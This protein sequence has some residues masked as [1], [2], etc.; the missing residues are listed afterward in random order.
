MPPTLKLKEGT[1]GTYTSFGGDWE[2]LNGHAA[3]LALPVDR[4][5]PPTTDQ[6][7]GLAREA[8][9]RHAAGQLGK[10]GH[11]YMIDNYG[12][13][14]DHE[15]VEPVIDLLKRVYTKSITNGK[16]VS[17]NPAQPV[18]QCCTTLATEGTFDGK[19]LWRASS[20]SSIGPAI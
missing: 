9:K 3:V 16:L 15:R 13:P 19:R 12:L 8:A 6:I 14:H 1:R 2:P 4:Q 17:N 20:G 10:S 18:L 5:P 7:K 11:R